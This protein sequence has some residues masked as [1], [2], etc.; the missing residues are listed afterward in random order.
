[1]SFDCGTRVIYKGPDCPHGKLG[2]IA[3]AIGHLGTPYQVV[4]WDSNSPVTHIDDCKQ[5]LCLLDNCKP[6]ADEV[7]E[8]SCRTCSKAN[9]SNVK[10]CWWCGNE[11]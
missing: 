11:P 2:T 9:D 3:E 1:M 5:Y 6:I 10:K 4:I 8:V 7:K